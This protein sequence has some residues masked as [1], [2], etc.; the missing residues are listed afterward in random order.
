MKIA[1][2][3]DTFPPQIDGV[4]SVAY[5]SAC[6]LAKRGH[7]VSVFIPKDNLRRKEQLE[8][9]W[10]F[11]VI[12]M[13]SLPFFGYPSH[14]FGLGIGIGVRRLRKKNVDIIHTH[15]PFSVGWEA[16]F[17][18]KFFGVP[19]VGTHHTFYD[20]YLRYIKL[21][22]EWGKKAS[23]KYIVRYYNLCDQVISPSR[24]LARELKKHGLRKSISVLANPI[25][26][27]FFRPVSDLVQKE[28]TKKKLGVKGK[29]L[30]YVGRVSYEK[31][32]DQ[33]IKAFGRAIKIIPDL[34]LVIVGDG[35]EKEKLENL[36]DRLKIRKNLKFTGYLRGKEL[37]ETLRAA[38]IFITAS[39]SENM[40][41]SI[42]EAM[43][44]GLPVI[45]VDALGIPEIVQDGKNGFIATPDNTREMAE[46]IIMLV[47]DKELINNFSANSRKIILGCSGEE[48]AKLQEQIYQKAIEKHES[49][50]LS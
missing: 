45:G 49:L 16:V 13:P 15:T 2:F 47:R 29:M 18:A 27:D 36:A 38:D 37:L 31:S 3:S 6:Q 12:E 50:S 24:A 22:Y 48:I 7:E 46:K 42:L 35:P 33:V 9:K 10:E 8:K 21:D 23:W 43:S 30:I 17:T 4:A 41:V 26:I 32:I 28:K 5:E 14:R 1:I 11:E 34:N 20:H 44:A 25:D 39:K 40:P 19:L